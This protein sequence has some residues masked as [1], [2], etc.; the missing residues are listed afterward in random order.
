MK[1]GRCCGFIGFVEYETMNRA[2]QLGQRG[3][4]GEHTFSLLL[5]RSAE[6]VGD[7]RACGV[8]ESADVFSG[9][10]AALLFL[11]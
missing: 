4:T 8:V 6:I 10:A 11:H 2:A 1:A 3:R 5:T 7:V 9:N